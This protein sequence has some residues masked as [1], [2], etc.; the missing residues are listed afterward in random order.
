MKFRAA[1]RA[2][3]FSSVFASIVANSWS[4][5]LERSQITFEQ[6]LSP[7]FAKINAILRDDRGFLWFGTTKGLFK[8]DGYRVRVFPGNSPLDGL[9]FSMLK[10]NDGSLL[11]GTG[12]GLWKFDL[13]RE[14]AA[15]FLT[16]KQFSGS[17][18]LAVA[19]DSTGAL[20]VGTG[21]QGLFRYDPATQKVQQF[22]RANGLGGNWITSLLPGHDKVLW[23]GTGGG[24]LNALDRTTSQIATYR[25]NVSGAGSLSSDHI[26]ALC[27]RAGREL[28]IGTDNGL[29]LLDLA[30]GHLR[31]L[32]IP[33]AIRHT[34]MSIACD[35]SGRVWIAATDLGLLS[36]SNG[37]FT[38]FK[39]SNDAGRSL[40]TILTLYPDPA[41]TTTTSLLLW[42]GT[43]SGV[44]KVLISANPFANHI[45]GEQSLQ[46]DR[47]A[48]LS[49]F[50]DRKGI[51]WVGLWGGGLD[52]LQRVNGVYRRVAHFE[53]DA[54]LASSLPSNDVEDIMED[55][56]RNLWI[57]TLNG[58]AMLDPDRNHMIVDRHV[59]GDSMSLAGDAVDRIH[60]GHSGTLWIC[61]TN[62]LSQLIPGSPHRFK[63]YLN[64][65]DD[66]HPVGGNEVSNILEDSLSNLWLATSGNGLIRLER[67][68]TFIKFVC[69]E[70]T[71]GTRCNWIYTLA[72]DRNGLFWLSTRGGLVSFDP[73]SRT[74]AHHAVGRPSDEHI[75]GIEVDQSNNLWLSTDIGLGKFNQKTGAFIRYEKDDGIPFTELPSRFF[76]STRGTLFVG[77]LDGFTEFAP[78]SVATAR[79]APAMAITGFSVFDRE[80]PATV[81]GATSVDLTYDQKSFS[82]SFA[83]L[84]YADPAR[85]SYAYRMVGLDTHWVDAGH[86]TYASYT[87]MD[88][89]AYVFQVKGSNSY[90][91]WNEAGTSMTIVISPPY[92]R[93]WWFRS[94]AVLLV[95]TMIY[96]AY[97]YRVRRLLDLE[98]LRLRIANDLHDDVGSNLSA[99]A[100]VSRALHRAPE[101][102]G[103]TRQ[104]L[105]EIY[106][107]A[108]LTSEGMKDL[109]WLIKP[110]N[111][112]LDDLF[113]RMKDTASAL[114]GE[115]PFEFHSPEGLESRAVGIDFKRSVFLAFKEIITN[116]A[117]HSGATAVE[118]Q[119]AL[120][121]R[122]LGMIISDN[123][124]GFDPSAPPRGNG[125][126]SL[127][128]RAEHIGGSCKIQSGPDHGTRVAF[129]ARL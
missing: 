56:K 83:A 7:N 5:G 15:P 110:E 81:F 105:G 107:T 93:T 79:T 102:S 10:M 38:P 54:L 33:S 125:L 108:V 88:P 45:R 53:R 44:D 13:A 117:K 64:R 82:F 6:I 69:P 111:D 89:G 50:E 124:K 95:A 60:E 85:N 119:I 127:H 87:N 126:Q 90:D 114:L 80:M 67:E 2:L 115:I 120:H 52:A 24:G 116:I 112:T 46:L 99:I 101:L 76:R 35:P 70:D 58:L 34:I 122:L 19:T 3:A 25:R 113:L 68:G 61:T 4:T 28:W 104:K 11:L 109:V 129:S 41:A 47:G 17:R 26:T 92:W 121:D 14:E 66:A 84:D 57:G 103:A 37:E 40:N 118:I 73:R 63:N 62:G 12:H 98:R 55:G 36:Y 42:V 39:T 49:L 18:I 48:V 71:S 20:W 8:Y 72:T 65:P 86:R 30:S 106:N 128:A 59:D 23:I 9:V 77:G 96:S 51:L 97:R 27:E 43:H 78:E 29:N 16:G 74:F 91:V 1:C 21:S 94:A 75:F 22:T 31:R 32:D 100:M 123:G